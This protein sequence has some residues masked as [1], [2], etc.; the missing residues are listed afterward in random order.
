MPPKAKRSFTVDAATGEV[1]CQDPSCRVTQCGQCN[2]EQNARKRAERK[3]KNEAA[4]RALKEVADEAAIQQARADMAEGKEHIWTYD[5]EDHD[6]GEKAMHALEKQVDQSEDDE[7]KLTSP[8]RIQPQE[9]TAEFALEKSRGKTT[10]NHTNRLLLFNCIQ[11]FNPFAS[12]VKKDA[13]NQVAVEMASSTALM[14][15]T[16]TGDFR[17]KTN[18]HGLEVFY[19]RQVDEMNKRTSDEGKISGQA[20]ATITKELAAEYSVLQSCVAKEKDATFIRDK[21]RQSKS[22][23]EDIRNNKVTQLVKEAA[24]EDPVVKARAFKLLQNKVRA[25]K[26]EAAVW[27]K[28]HCGLGKYSYNDQQLA[29]I[30]YLTVLKKDFPEDSDALPESD[31]VVEK[32]KGGVAHAIGN[33][34]SKLPSLAPPTVDAGLFAQAFFSAKREHQDRVAAAAPRKRTLSERLAD[35]QQQHA[36]NVISKDELLHYEAE[37]KKQYFLM[38]E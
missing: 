13:W 11:K 10:W 35:V 33:L 2:K 3:T 31:G 38:Q 9:R 28:N 25:A 26:L 30:E 36:D 1:R 23:L 5:Q 24:L 22:A 32:K 27:E 15:D 21:K 20:G 17:V 34:V 7:F 37:I 4:G 18:G 14:R 12:Q 6:E 8:E 29:D 19:A 16:K